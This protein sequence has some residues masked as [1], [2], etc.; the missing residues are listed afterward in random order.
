MKFKEIFWINDGNGNGI[1]EDLPRSSQSITVR[2]LWLFK[3]GKPEKER[4]RSF[5]DFEL[6]IPPTFLLDL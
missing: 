4:V 5:E 3:S 1:G 6:K 2:E